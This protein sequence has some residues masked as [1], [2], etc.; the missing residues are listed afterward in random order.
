MPQRRKPGT[1]ARLPIRSGHDRPARPGVFETHEGSR[2]PSM[3][4]SLE[5]GAA[6]GPTIDRPPITG[7]GGGLAGLPERTL[8]NG[9]KALVLPRTHAPV[10]VCDL[11]YPAGSVDEPAGRSGLAHFVE[12]ML[13][14]G[15]NG[16]PRARSTGSRSWPPGNRT[17]RPARIARTTGSRSR[18]TAGSWP[19]K[20][21]PTGWRGDLRRARG[22]GRATRD[23]RRAGPRPRL[24]DG[25]AGPDSPGRLPISGTPTATRS[26]VGPMTWLGLE[27]RTSAPSTGS[28]IAP[29]VRS[30]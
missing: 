1:S 7:L 20:S 19:S 18:P 10:V 13:F 5:K 30:S 25:P 9:F 28:T 21:R 8:G 17:R 11:Y 29:M 6:N 22:R 3:S 27:S 24:A 26:S 2:S 15:P 12:H 4:L 14:K 23:R 16:S